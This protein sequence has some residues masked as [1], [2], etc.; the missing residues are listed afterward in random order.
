MLDKSIGD[1]LLSRP[2]G[3][4]AGAVL[5]AIVIGCMSVQIGGK[6]YTCASLEDGVFVQEGEVWVPAGGMQQV[7]YPVPYCAPPNLELDPSANKVQVAEQRSDS[8]TVNNSSQH[9]IR[10]PWKARGLRAAPPVVPSPL[11]PPAMEDH[12]ATDRP[13]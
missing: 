13:G 11:P 2:V 6:S 5:V 3:I 7:Y 8:F 4:T 10:V 9:R 12:R 1:L